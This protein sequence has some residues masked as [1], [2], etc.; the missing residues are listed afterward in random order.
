MLKYGGGSFDPLTIFGF[1]LFAFLYLSAIILNNEIL[2]ISSLSLLTSVNVVKSIRA[3]GFLSFDLGFHVATL[4]FIALP[5]F[6]FYDAAEYGYFYIPNVVNLGFNR[7]EIIKTVNIIT[8]G[9][10]AFCLGSIFTSRRRAGIKNYEFENNKPTLRISTLILYFIV[11]LIILGICV[12]LPNPSRILLSGAGGILISLAALSSIGLSEGKW[13][14]IFF[15]PPLLGAFL[16]GNRGSLLTVLILMIFSKFRDN[17]SFR[18]MLFIIL[19]GYIVVVILSGLLLDNRNAGRQTYNSK[20]ATPWQRFSSEAIMVPTMGVMVR[21]LDNGEIKYQNGIDFLLIPAFFVPRALWHD[22]PM[23]LDFRLNNALRLN[24]GDTFGTPVTIF[25]SFFINLGKLFYYPSMFMLGLLSS[26]YLISGN[27]T[28]RILLFT[29]AIDLVRV[30]DISREVVTF[31]IWISSYYVVFGMS[32][33]RLKAG[34][35]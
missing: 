1:I 18:K 34:G 24:S 27:K 35:V 31:I 19:G 13:G 12:I 32:K 20:D 21:S 4:I 5:S 29:F 11:S 6:Y 3:T 16:S 22:K 2:L 10:A 8:L 14:W 7:H 9:Y 17:I 23:P 30:G 28:I 33:F 15:I 25:G 26:K